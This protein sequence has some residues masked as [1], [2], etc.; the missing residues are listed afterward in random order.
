VAEPTVRITRR[1]WEAIPAP[2]P[3]TP[4]AWRWVEPEDLSEAIGLL[5]PQVATPYRLR[6]D[7]LGYED[8][9]RGLKVPVQ[10]VA[11]RLFRARRQ[12]RAILREHLPPAI[13]E[14]VPAWRS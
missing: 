13:R 8:I 9:S 7:G 11:R 12:L 14:E 2:E 5:P 3:A 1:Q 4:Q 6:L 10:I